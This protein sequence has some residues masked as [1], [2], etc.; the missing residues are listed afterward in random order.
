MSNTSWLRL[1]F[2]SP[3]AGKHLISEHGVRLRAMSNKHVSCSLI[4]YADEHERRETFWTGLEVC[5]KTS[6]ELVYTV[7]VGCHSR[8]LLRGP[9]GRLAVV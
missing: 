4:L 2:L 1:P 5:P 6:I 9:K 7:G 8:G 3:G